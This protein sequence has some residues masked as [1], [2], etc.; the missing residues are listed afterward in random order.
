MRLIPKSKY[1]FEYKGNAEKVCSLLAK[2]T[3]KTR[4]GK[5]IES[6]EG[7]LFSGFI[8]RDYFRIQHSGYIPGQ[9][10]YNKSL[11]AP[12]VSGKIKKIEGKGR[13]SVEVRHSLPSLIRVAF[14]MFFFMTSYLI[15]LCFELGK[16]L[17]GALAVVVL[18]FACLVVRSGYAIGIKET[19]QYLEEALGVKMEE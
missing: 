9:E 5:P 18:V 12:V 7:K 14:L 17:P 4:F 16:F 6:R 19:T 10:K 11:F 3:V 2:N 1:Q 13:V 15:Y 8:D